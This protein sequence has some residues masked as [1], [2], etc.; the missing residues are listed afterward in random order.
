MVEG[1]SVEHLEKQFGGTTRAA[2]PASQ[3]VGAFDGSGGP[4]AFG[5]L[6]RGGVQLGAG[7]EVVAGRSGGE[8]GG[9]GDLA[10]GDGVGTFLD[11]EAGG[12]GGH[13]VL[14]LGAALLDGPSARG[15]GHDAT[16]RGRR[17][18]NRGNTY[19]HV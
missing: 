18:R 11:E 2:A 7:R 9:G 5:G 6:D 14:A 12:R 1:G 4:D 15:R 8:S 16:L 17:E 19:T 10:V 3:R 13:G